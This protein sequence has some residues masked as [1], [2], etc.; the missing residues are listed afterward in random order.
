M[1]GLELET[2]A[3]LNSAMH[4]YIYIYEFVNLS[5]TVEDPPDE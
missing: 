5:R 1:L 3:G 4:I 2:D